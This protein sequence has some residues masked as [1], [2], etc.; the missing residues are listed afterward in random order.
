MYAVKNGFF[1][2]HTNS[3]ICMNGC[4]SIINGQL[5]GNYMF[6]KEH[7]SQKSTKSIC[8]SYHSCHSCSLKVNSQILKFLIELKILRI[9]GKNAF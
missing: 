4:C 9:S 1:L 6:R 8:Y 5:H 2:S 7:E 3:K